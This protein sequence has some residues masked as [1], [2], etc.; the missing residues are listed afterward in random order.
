MANVSERLVDG[1]IRN[2]QEE[3]EGVQS[4][5]EQSESR[6]T[7][8]SSELEALRERVREL[9]AQAE[10]AE[11][12]QR[13]TA[14]ALKERDEQ[15][16]HLQLR[17]DEANDEVQRL[18]LM[19][20]SQLSAANGAQSDVASTVRA[21]GERLPSRSAPL[22]GRSPA[23]NA[24]LSP[25]NLQ[26]INKIMNN[27]RARVRLLELNQMSRYLREPS[28]EQL[29]TS[30]GEEAAASDAESDQKPGVKRGSRD[31][32]MY[33]DL[34]GGDLR[35]RRHR[36][37]AATV[38]IDNS[39]EERARDAARG[40]PPVAPAPAAAANAQQHV[41]AEAASKS[42]PA[43]AQEKEQKQRQKQE[44]QAS[45]PA[46]ETAAGD[47]DGLLGEQLES[48]REHIK[49]SE[50]RLREAGQKLKDLNLN[51]KYEYTQRE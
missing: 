16:V 40:K 46:D 26:S 21:P 12:G 44:Q 45:A 36:R 43:V 47:G 1:R 5:L 35:P 8:Q 4:E 39:S 9:E 2:L 17:L 6:A 30:S 14:R 34:L 25:A 18:R 15:L 23:H 13:Q 50:L 48:E 28:G 3:L 38:T 31:S 32:V 33:R 10:L 19:N 7:E 24:A 37:R 20:L 11:S 41:S 29:E 51:I 22:A 49:M 27:F 42:K